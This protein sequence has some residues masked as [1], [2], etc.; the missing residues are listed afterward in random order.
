MS[1]NKKYENLRAEILDYIKDHNLKHGDKLP[2]VR[3]IIK[4]SLYSYT[5]VNRTLQELE[6]EGLIT[7]TQGKGIFVN[8]IDEQVSNA[9]QIALIVPKDF[10]AHKILLDILTGVR[11]VVEEHQYGLL[12]SISNM[13]HE[14][15]KI[16]INRLIH[17]NV[18]G[19]I[20]FLEDNY[21]K[22]YSHIVDLKKKNYPFV[23]VD[24]HIPDLNTDYV[25]INNE[26]GMFNVC[27]YL[28]YNRFCDRIIFIASND[29]SIAA[30][31]SNEKIDGYTKA[32]K[33]LYGSD[34]SK[35]YTLAN[36]VD[37]IDEIAAANHN[38][39]VCLN[40][41]TM[42]VDL[43]LRLESAHKELPSNL[44]LFGYNNSY[45][46]PLFPTVEQFNDEVGRKAAQIL[47][48]KFANPDQTPQQILIEPKLVLPAESGIY[49]VES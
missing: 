38:V 45:Q 24:R 13:S 12:I 44:H 19:L 35:V 47:F 49:Y 5:T 31:S 7:K 39:G 22:D 43:N 42:I 32:V 30:A 20:I 28:K 8:R 25:G 1:S 9:R 15:E 37:E 26:H 27:S 6:N 17:N 2:T 36:F 41:D 11:Q 40:H 16:T 23:L 29:A 46:N 3:E 10:S 18:A 21:L 14:K 33:T 48:Q 4:T 34:S